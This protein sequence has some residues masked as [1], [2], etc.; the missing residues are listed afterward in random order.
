MYY[1]QCGQDKIL[2]ENIFKGFKNGIFIDVGAHDGVSFNNTLYFKKTH[3]W[4]GI[5]I[6]PIKTVYD[7]LVINRPND[8]NLMYET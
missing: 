4:L 3:N 8:I 6:E 5:N 7:K 1:A 2:E